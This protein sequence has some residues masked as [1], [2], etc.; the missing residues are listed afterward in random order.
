[1]ELTITRK[2]QFIDIFRKYKI[3]VDD[4]EIAS[5][6]R[7]QTLKLDVE[8]GKHTLQLKIDWESSNK[9]EF[10]SPVKFECGNGNSKMMLGYPED[11]YLCVVDIT[12]SEVG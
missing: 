3:F 5:I 4:K 2:K 1:M 7:G 10:D 8:P 6:G 11:T 9:V 12:H